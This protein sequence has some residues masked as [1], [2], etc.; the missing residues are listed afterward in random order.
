RSRLLV[1]LLH[2]RGIR[3]ANSIDA[4]LSAGWSAPNDTL[5]NLA[6]AMYRIQ[7]AIR[8]GER[9]MVFSDFDCD[10]LTSCALLTVVCAQLGARVVPHVPSR[11]DD[12]RGLNAAAIRDFAAQGASLIITTDCGT[13]NVAEVELAKTLGIDVVVTDHHPLH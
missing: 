8:A 10:G 12:G 2:N 5:P 4:F 1:Q 9:I 6:I 11:E 13:A 7:A 3:G